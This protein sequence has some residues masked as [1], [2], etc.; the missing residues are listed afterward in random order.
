MAARV[1]AWLSLLAILYV[2]ISP[3][4]LR[5]D[6]GEPP[7]IERFVAFATAGFLFAMGYPRRIW[8]VFGLVMVAAL[9][10]EAA[11]LLA[12]TRHAHLSDA[13]FKGAGGTLGVAAGYVVNRAF[14]RLLPS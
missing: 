10:F 13:F 12:P 3:I 6:S 5:P 14:A 1:L 9:G 8:L 2:T 4:G 7:D 11:Q